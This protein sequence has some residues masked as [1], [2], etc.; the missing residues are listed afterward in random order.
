MKRFPILVIVTILIGFSFLSLAQAKWYKGNTHAHSFWSDGDAFPEM[1][2][3]WYK[4]H[5]YNFLAMSDHNTAMSDV[6]YRTQKELLKRVPDLEKYLAECA[7]AFGPKTIKFIERNGEKAVQLKTFDE[8]KKLTAEPGIFLPIQ[9]DEVSYK[10]GEKETHVTV[11]N[12]RENIPK[13]GGNTAT[14]A[15]TRIVKAAKEAAKKDKLNTF[16][17]LNHPNWPKYDIT[18]ELL[19]SLTD[20]NLFEVINCHSGCNVLGDKEHWSCEKLWD[21][22]NT[23][24]LGK[25]KSHPLFGIASDD[26]HRYHT[27][28]P[29]SAL[30]G[31]GFIMVK[32][33]QLVASKLVEAVKKGDFYSSTGVMLNELAYNP[34]TKTLRIEVDPKA[35]TKY[36]IEFIGTRRG[37][38]PKRSSGLPVYSDAIGE[39]FKTVKGTSGEYTL[40]GDELYVRAAVRSDRAMK[41]PCGKNNPKTEQAWTQPVGWK[42]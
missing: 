32:A 38:S 2:A 37:V 14:E 36:T 33:D 18:P 35:D 13:L 10:S 40:T 12:V 16:W 30:P 3:K 4:D 28:N 1:E 7:E 17:Q 22:A 21:V 26:A 15:F 41:R 42:N 11:F 34:A 5:G 23:I 8:V 9:A 27:E 31:R 24:R 25:M 6:K 39:V 19:A 20:Y 29:N